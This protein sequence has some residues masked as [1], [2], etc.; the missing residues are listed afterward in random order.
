MF[1]CW[2]SSCHA[3]VL[4]YMALARRVRVSVRVRLSVRVRVSVGV[5]CLE[6]EEE[7][8]RCVY[9]VVMAIYSHCAHTR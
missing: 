6:T 7:R 5:D 4:A 1:L 9:E 3:L 2:T 8:A